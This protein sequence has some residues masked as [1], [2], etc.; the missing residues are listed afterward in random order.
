MNAVTNDTNKMVRL[1]L[2]ALYLHERNARAKKSYKP[3]SIR[4]LAECIAELGLW[5][6]LV[7]IPDDEALSRAGVVAGGRR[8]AALELLLSEG[9]ITDEYLVDAKV[10]SE[11]AEAISMAENTQRENMH[12]ADEYDRIREMYDDHGYSVDRIADL[13][14]IT[15]LVV[16]RRMQLSKA[17]PDLLADFRLNKLTTDQLIALCASTDQARQ[18]EVWTEMKHYYNPSPAALRKRVLET[19]VDCSTDARIRLIGGVAAFESAGGIVE[20]DMFSDAQ[21]AGFT[22]DVGLLDKLVAEKLQ[23]A[24]DD[25]RA[26][27]WSFVTVLPD[28]PNNEYWRLGTIRP[29]QQEPSEEL[30][31]QMATL[32]DED[33]LLSERQEAHEDDEDGTSE[34]DEEAYEELLTRR[35]EIKAQ[36]QAMQESVRGSYTDEQKAAAGVVLYLNNGVIAIERGKV[37]SADRN[38]AGKASGVAVEGGRETASAG[39]KENAISDPLRRSL[40]GRRNAYVQVEVARNPALAKILLAQRFAGMLDSESRG[41]YGDRGVCDLSLSGFSDGARLNHPIIGADADELNGMLW[42]VVEPMLKGMPSKQDAQWDFFAA[43]SAVELDAIIACGVGMAVSVNAVHGGMTA[44]LLD[45]MSF[46]LSDHM[47]VT[48]DSYFTRVPKAVAIDALKDAGQAHDLGTL[49]GMKKGP[50]AAEAESRISNTNWLPALIRT[51]APKTP[52]VAKTAT[53]QAPTKGATTPAAAKPGKQTTAKKPV[54]KAKKA[55]A[56]P[57]KR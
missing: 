30:A 46:Q 7:V 18:L 3:D 26:E 37:Q 21:N 2:K 53:K 6:N 35:E 41:T 20:R 10:A 29:T 16:E 23:A 57:T 25:I 5:Q 38:A 32:N 27:G 22:K 1:P 12:P 24:A 50:L 52:K 36:L 45:A 40:L 31:A 55:T 39:R 33:E 44:K 8:L 42:A 48:A 56:K 4:S 34:L 19:Q 13:L 14:G 47:K 28:G 9:R 17:H 15:A 11:F 49:E 43:K 51:P 54:D